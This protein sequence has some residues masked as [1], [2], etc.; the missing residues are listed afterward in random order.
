MSEQPLSG[1]VALV[2]GAS[3]GIGAAIAERFAE[4]GATVVVTARTVDPATSKLAGTIHETVER[5]TESGGEA[6]AIAA[7]LSK[8][9]RARTT[10]RRD[11]ETGRTGRRAGQQRGRHLLH[12]R[13]RF[14]RQTVPVDVR[15]RGHRAVPFGPVGPARDDREAAKDG[16]STSPPARR[17][18][19]R[20]RPIPP[21]T[22]AA[23]STGCAR[24]RSSDSRPVWP[25]RSTT[26]TWR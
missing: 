6:V 12:P 26:T 17:A 2:T 11:D 19:P 7:D 25:P 20:S 21:A 1:K 15:G 16:S 9:C 4:E 5:I 18:I 24:P 13:R 14:R 23:P 8:V 3:R 10:R 22:L